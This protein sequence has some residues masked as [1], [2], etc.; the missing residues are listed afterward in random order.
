MEGFAVEVGV[1]VRVEV[2]VEVVEDTVE[3]ADV[4]DTDDRDDDLSSAE[5]NEEEWVMENNVRGQ[6]ARRR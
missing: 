2:G 1:E 4:L 6:G 3:D 5:I